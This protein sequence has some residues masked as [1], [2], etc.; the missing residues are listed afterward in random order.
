MSL[1]GQNE[2]K[3]KKKLFKNKKKR[4]KKFKKIKKYPH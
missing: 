4:I 1:A 3:R 2:G